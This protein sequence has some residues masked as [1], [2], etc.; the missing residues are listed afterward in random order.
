M[1]TDAGWLRA[2]G[3]CRRPPGSQKE[4]RMH[5]KLSFNVIAAT[6]A[7]LGMS[8]V[9]GC[10]SGTA[11]PARPGDATEGPAGAGGPEGT[12]T[13]GRAEAAAAGSMEAQAEG[14]G[15]AATAPTTEAGS[16]PAAPASEEAK[17]AA[18]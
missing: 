11:E 4:I 17:P 3:E 5:Q 10:G 15:A 6:L 7:A 8:S 12:T 1:I 13:G 9:V 16:E 18:A 2:A 14:S